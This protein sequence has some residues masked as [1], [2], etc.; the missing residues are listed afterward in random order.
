MVHWEEQ[1]LWCIGRNSTYGAFDDT[2]NTSNY[3]QHQMVA[4]LTNNYKEDGSGRGLILGNIL[5]LPWRKL[6]N[7]VT[8]IPLCFRTSQ[9]VC[10]KCVGLFCMVVSKRPVVSANCQN[11]TWQ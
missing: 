5:R 2:S 3:L 9:A 11:H 7:P 10:V 6:R 1:H 4:L 8:T